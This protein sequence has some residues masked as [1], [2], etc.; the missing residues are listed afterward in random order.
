[1]NI[2]PLPNANFSIFHK[3]KFYDFNIYSSPSYWWW[4][5]SNTKL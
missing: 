4:H 2:F 3:K 5:K 1:V